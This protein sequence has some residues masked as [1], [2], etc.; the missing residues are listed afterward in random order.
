MHTREK[1]KK[2]KESLSAS[3]IFSVISVVFVFHQQKINVNIAQ[4]F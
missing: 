3:C 4:I 2:R 1:P